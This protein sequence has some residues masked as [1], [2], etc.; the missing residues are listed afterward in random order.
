M[1]DTFLDFMLGPMR[2][3]GNFYFENQLILNALIV[4]IALYKIVSSKKKKAKN[5]PVS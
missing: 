2:S 1:M 3:I 5:E 4:G